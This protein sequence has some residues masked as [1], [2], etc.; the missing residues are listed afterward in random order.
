MT[1]SAIR[2]CGGMRHGRAEDHTNRTKAYTTA[3]EPAHG[4]LSRAMERAA[5]RAGARAPS[6]VADRLRPGRPAA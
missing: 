5:A 3:R 6:R 1:A 4:G 2:P